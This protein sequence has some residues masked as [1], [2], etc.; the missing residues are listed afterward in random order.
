[1]CVNYVHGAVSFSIPMINSALG[2]PRGLHRRAQETIDVNTQCTGRNIVLYSKHV[3]TLLQDADMAISAAA[4]V[5]DCSGIRD[6]DRHRM[7]RHGDGYTKENMLASGL[8][9]MAVSRANGA[10]KRCQK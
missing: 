5:R 6:A 2:S 10:V 1:M 9:Q 8:S 4:L 3:F 7:L